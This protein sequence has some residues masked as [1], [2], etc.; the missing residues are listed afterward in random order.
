MAIASL[1][2]SITQPYA[3]SNEDLTVISLWLPVPWISERKLYIISWLSQ[4]LSNHILKLFTVSADT[5]YEFQIFT[6]PILLAKQNL[7]KSYFVF[8]CN[9]N[10]QTVTSRYCRTNPN[11]RGGCLDHIFQLVFYTFRSCHLESSIVQCR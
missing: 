6:R 7:H 4:N 1:P 10:S 9:L 11:Q 8:F 3:Y 2:D 5:T